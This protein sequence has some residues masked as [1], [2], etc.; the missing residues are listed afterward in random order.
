MTMQVLVQEVVAPSTFE[1][2]LRLLYYKS[3]ILVAIFA[4][5]ALYQL[6]LAKEA[7]Q[8][9]RK[10]IDVAS[11]AL[12]VAKND[13]EVRSEREAVALAAERCEKFAEETLPRCAEKYNEIFSSGLEKRKW[14]LSD[15]DLQPQS[16][17]ER[18]DARQWLRDLQSKPNH[19]SQVAAILNDLEAFAIYFAKGAA[20]EKVAYPAIG[21]V[22]CEWTQVF[23]P[24]LAEVRSTGMDT[25]T[26]GKYQ[27]IVELYNIWESRSRREDLEAEADRINNQINEISDRSID[28]IGIGG[29]GDQKA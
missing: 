24:Y 16:L 22:F 7:L 18:Q 8:A 29:A 17:K 2:V 27:N 23:A 25:V 19:L 3:G 6:K 5:A 20:D 21:A 13:I 10:Q 28:P 9:T 12:K 26:S 1:N 14:A 11:E 15:G 4:G